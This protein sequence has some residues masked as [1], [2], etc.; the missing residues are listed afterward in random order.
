MDTS[1]LADYVQRDVVLDMQSMYV[2]LGKLIGIDHRYLVLENAD[3][4]DLRE[5]TTTRERYV[6]DSRLHGIRANRARALINRAEV[7]SISLIEDVIE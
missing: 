3:I 1:L 2:C 4:H 7:V 6:L 5:T